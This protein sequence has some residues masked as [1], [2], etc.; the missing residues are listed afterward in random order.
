[1]SPASPN[2]WCTWSTQSVRLPAARRALAPLF[3]GDQSRP[4]T[5]DS[6]CEEALFGP[7]GWTGFYPESRA[8]LYFLL[9]DGWDVA[10]GAHPDVPPGIAQFG[11]MAPDPGRFPSLSG[12]P[13]ERLAELTRRVTDAGWRGLGLWVAPQS[14]GDK[15][16][17]EWRRPVR[18][19]EAQD[20][21]VR[22]R[23]RFLPEG[24]LGRILRR[25]RLPANAH[26]H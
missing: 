6:L 11:A 9:D 23:R 4:T 19:V 18:G 25:H 8:D 20:R 1:M 14:Q 21:L 12:T 10:F 5:R 13:G 22:R 26:G 7:E 15:G 2:Y 17:E 16:V 24:G 3:G